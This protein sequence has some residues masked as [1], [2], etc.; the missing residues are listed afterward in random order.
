L[1]PALRKYLY[2]H[3]RA[4]PRCGEAAAQPSGSH[5]LGVSDDPV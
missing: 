3:Q 4:R 5:R 1:K 2:L